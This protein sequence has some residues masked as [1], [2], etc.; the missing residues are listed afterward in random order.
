MTLRSE[1]HFQPMIDPQ[2]NL[3]KSI[4]RILSREGGPFHI[5][6][7]LAILRSYFTEPPHLWIRYDPWIYKLGRPWSQTARELDVHSIVPFVP[8]DNDSL[9][10]TNQANL[11]MFRRN[12]P[13]ITCWYLRVCLPT[14]FT[15]ARTRLYSLFDVVDEL[16]C[17]DRDRQPTYLEYGAVRGRGVSGWRP[18]TF[19]NGVAR[20]D[21]PIVLAVMAYHWVYVVFSTATPMPVDVVV[22]HGLLES[23]VAEACATSPLDGYPES[24]R[25]AMVHG[26]LP[27]E[28]S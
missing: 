14:R 22:V 12:H 13:V 3:G 25:F 27:L 15:Q 26:L 21:P 20:L 19:V 16:R 5:V 6:I 10:L 7:D 18:L 11:E 9:P 23:G 28:S 4:D 17:D 8:G 2:S 24:E 1:C